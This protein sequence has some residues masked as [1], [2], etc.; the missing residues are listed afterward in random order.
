V[1]VVVGLVISAYLSAI[2]IFEGEAI[3]QRP[4]LLLGVLLI[5]V[6]I[7]L[8]TLGLVG[9]MVAATRQDIGGRRSREL[10]VERVVPDAYTY[11]TTSAKPR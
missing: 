10:Q 3:G 4:L 5:V 6:G 11:S 2:K 1:L 7:Q 9:E 8:F